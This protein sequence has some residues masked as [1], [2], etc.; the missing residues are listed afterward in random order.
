MAEEAYKV[1]L[2]IDPGPKESAI[3]VYGA[4]RISDHATLKNDEV[5]HRISGWGLG[6]AIEWIVGYG[7]TVGNET[8]DTCRWVGRFEQ[9]AGCQE[10]DGHLVTRKEIKLHLCDSLQAND[11]HVR[12]A[13]IDRIGPPCSKKAPGPTFGIVGHE[14]SALACAVTWWDKHKEAL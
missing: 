2:A 10:G 1:I 14:W 3:V 5:L 12:Q 7:L 11:S 6:I 4:G 9:A 13:L 8:F